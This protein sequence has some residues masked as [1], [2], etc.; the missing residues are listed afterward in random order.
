[1]S[2]SR[3]SSLQEKPEKAF[4]GQGDQGEV[5]LIDFH[6]TEQQEPTTDSE[7]SDV[8]TPKEGQL[9]FSKCIISTF[10]FLLLHVYMYG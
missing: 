8:G 4:I 5:L 6:S 7:T 3:Q 10:H 2:L 9:Q 1:M